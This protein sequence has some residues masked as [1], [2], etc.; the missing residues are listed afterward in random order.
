MIYF[1]IRQPEKTSIV[2]DVFDEVDVRGDEG[3]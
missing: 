2:M 1:C 3:C